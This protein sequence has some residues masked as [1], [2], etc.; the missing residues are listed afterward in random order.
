MAIEGWE[1]VNPRQMEDVKVEE[2]DLPSGAQISF[3]GAL[4]VGILCVSIYIYI[5]MYIYIY[6]YHNTYTHIHTMHVIC[7]TYKVYIKCIYIYIYAYMY[8]YMCIYI[9]IYIHIYV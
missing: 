8:I 2:E 5:S 3:G 9:F 1:A 4:Q 6:M 7:N